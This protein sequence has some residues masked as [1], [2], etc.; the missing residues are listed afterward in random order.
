VQPEGRSRSGADRVIDLLREGS[1][2]IGTLPTA[3]DG[4]PELDEEL[5]SAATALATRLLA[6]KTRVTLADSA[7][8]GPQEIEPEDIGL[9]ATHRAMNAALEAALPAPLRGR[10]RVDTPERWQ[11]LERKLMLVV[12][13]LSSVARPSS[14]DLETGRLCVMASRHK[15]GLIVVSR[16]H[17]GDTLDGLLL[18][19]D[20]PVG[21]PDISGRGHAQHLRLWSELARAGRIQPLVS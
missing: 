5:A 12:H 20:Q 4:P 1:V 3:D 18:A 10:V 2:A 8:P 16:D 9:A 17:I 19:A 7:N 11:G 14:F 15:A 21:R 6:R 13:P